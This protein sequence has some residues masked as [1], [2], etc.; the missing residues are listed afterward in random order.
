MLHIKVAGL[1][2]FPDTISAVAAAAD[3]MYRLAACWWRHTNLLLLLWSQ[4]S[5]ATNST[6]EDSLKLE[7]AHST[8]PSC[9]LEI[10]VA[11]CYKES[12]TSRSVSRA[13]AA[14]LLESCCVF[15]SDSRNKHALMS[16]CQALSLDTSFMSVSPPINLA[17]RLNVDVLNSHYH[18]QFRE[19]NL[20]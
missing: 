16:K 6:P 8:H 7:Y 11:G 9:C 4:E 17:P 10:S 2:C 20:F 5:L 1:P 12:D 19:N 13:A 14:L 15:G 3:W 18:N